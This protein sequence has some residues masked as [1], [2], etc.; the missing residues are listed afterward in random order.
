M[1]KYQRNYYIE[2]EDINGNTQTLSYPLTLDFQ[3]TRNYMGDVQE[4]SFTIYNLGEN[5]R[6]LIT[7]N[8]I[9]YLSPKTNDQQNGI[10][11]DIKFYAG[12]GP[13]I[14]LPL[15]FHGS[16]LTCASLREEGSPDWQTNISC[17]DP[18]LWPTYTFSVPVAQGADRLGTVENLAGQFGCSLGKVGHLFDDD[19]TFSSRANMM[20]DS[21]LSILHKMTGGNRSGGNFFFENKTLN[22]L[23]DNEAWTNPAFN[24]L[25]ANTGLLGTPYYE[26]TYVFANS[27]FEPRVQMAQILTLDSEE[28]SWLNGDKKVVAYT[29][30]GTIS[31]SVEGKCQTQIQLF[32]LLSSSGFDIVPG[33]PI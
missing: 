2:I 3:I 6:R 17:Y 28:N 11:R 18:G 14:G 23:M 10:V 16:V 8:T 26:Q 32:A 12:Y 21:G 15:V 7:K 19:P 13:T 9:D 29:H 5:T 33:G 30:G 1:L 24:T 22:L 20:T 25:S 27:L 4:A 31:G